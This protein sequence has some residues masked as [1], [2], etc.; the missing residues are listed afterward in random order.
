VISL[1]SSG[2]FKNTDAF[3]R[4]MSKGDIFS[5]L[6]DYGSK[7]VSALASATPVSSGLTA[8]SWNYEVKKKGQ[9]YSIIWTNSNLKAGVPLVILLQYGHGTRNGGYVQGRDFINP[10]IKPIFDEIAEGVWRV[11]TSS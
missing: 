5:V 6:N 4:R 8:S 1:E 3:L 10:A 11:V 9:N 2:S 7:G